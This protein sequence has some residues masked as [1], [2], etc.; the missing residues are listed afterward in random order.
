MNHVTDGMF[1]VTIRLEVP[2]E[3]KRRSSLPT[4]KQARTPPLQ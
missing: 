3:Q 1:Y 4:N 2:E